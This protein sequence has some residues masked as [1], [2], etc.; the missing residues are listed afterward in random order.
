MK[1]EKIE[2]LMYVYNELDEKEK[3][4]V[5]THLAGCLSCKALFAEIS[6]QHSIIR[7]VGL[8]PVFATSPVRITR[9]IMQTIETSNKSSI[10]KVVSIFSAFWLRAAL[11]VASFLLTGFFFAELDAGYSRTA[12]NSNNMTSNMIRLNTS[13]FLEAHKRR[14]ETSNQISFYDCLK[15]SDCDYLKNLKTNKNL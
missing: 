3:N 14:R 1:C 5:N 9:N 15:L 6:H 10:E 7:K 11:A 4:Q 2:T 8:M 12:A 13:K